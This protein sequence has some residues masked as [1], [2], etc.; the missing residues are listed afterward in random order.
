MHENEIPFTPSL[1]DIAQQL[2]Q[3]ERERQAT[4][5]HN[6]EFNLHLFEE[7]LKQYMKKYDLASSA[8]HDTKSIQEH[9]LRR[10]PTYRL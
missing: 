6:T 10:F 9:G 4:E 3:E 8:S 7:F 2:I 5:R 1:D